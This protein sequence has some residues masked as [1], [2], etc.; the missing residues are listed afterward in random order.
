[1][2]RVHHVNT[3]TMCPFGGSLI[4]GGDGTRFAR[5]TMVCHC[6]VVETKAGLVLVDTGLYATTD[7]ET[8]RIGVI[9]QAALAAPLSREELA[10]SQ[11][12]ALGFSPKD[13]RNVIPTHLD[14]DHA[15][16]LADFPH[17]A[18]HVMEKEHAAAIA[19]AR[20]FE[21]RRYIPR[22][23]EGVRFI[24]H[25]VDGETWKGFDCVRPLPETG[26]EVLLVPLYGHSRGHAGVAVKNDDGTWIVHCGD[27]YFSKQEIA[28][29]VDAPPAL[30]FFQRNVAI[31]DKMRR[32]N[33]DRVRT[34]VK[35]HA[36]VRVFSAHSLAELED[37]RTARA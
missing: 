1:M 34:L 8:L 6:L 31:D 5:A 29:G 10:L 37:F 25:E 30:E 15:G 21:K 19:R 13:V 4:M 28:E 22:H 16:G 27:A 20:F 33:R 2:A 3:T 36:D 35:D 9:E 24:R 17:A 18:V 14:L 32:K 11:V 26:D 23:F 7:F 12:K